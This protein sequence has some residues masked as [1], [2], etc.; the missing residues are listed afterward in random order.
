MIESNYTIIIQLKNKKQKYV[1]K[2]S[3]ENRRN[4]L[5]AKNITKINIEICIKIFYTIGGQKTKVH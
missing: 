5:H 4:Q 3:Y 1:K 2:H